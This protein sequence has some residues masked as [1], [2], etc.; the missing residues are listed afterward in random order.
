MEA[1]GKAIRLMIAAGAGVPLHFLAEGESATRATA[2]EMGTATFR[3]FS[4]RQ[5]VFGA[6]V[7]DVIRV[8]ARRAGRPEPDVRVQFE[9][10]LEEDSRS[11]GRGD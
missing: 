2:R 3:H 6:I 1:D 4:H 11:D 10:V 8:A 9:A 5:H 7:E